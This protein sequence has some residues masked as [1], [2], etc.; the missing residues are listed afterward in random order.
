MPTS[1]LAVY[2]QDPLG[3]LARH[4]TGVIDD[5]SH[6]WLVTLVSGEGEEGGM[7]MGMW[8]MDER[9]RGMLSQPSI[10]ASRL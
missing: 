7:E 10:Y 8:E 4:S 5:R 3:G 9:V 1:A 6:G 2:P